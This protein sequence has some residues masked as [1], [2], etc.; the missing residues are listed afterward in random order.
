MSSTYVIGDV[1]GNYNGLV[2]SLQKMGW[3]EN[4]DRLI[5]V[6]DLVD[7]GIANKKVVD[8]VAEHKDTVHVLGNHEQQHKKM[9]QYYRILAKNPTVR[10]LAAGIFLRFTERERIIRASDEINAMYCDEKERKEFLNT[11]PKTFLDY[12]KHF[13]VYTM[14]WEDD[15]LWKLMLCLLDEMCGAPY[16]AQHTIYEY[17]AGSNKTR[18]RFEAV[19]SNTAAEFKIITT[20]ALARY[21]SVR[22]THNNPFGGI[23]SYDGD[24]MLAEHKNTLYVFGHVPHDKIIRIDRERSGCT[25]LD[26]D[27]S[28]DKV[29]IVRLEDI[30]GIISCNLLQS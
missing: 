4:E 6:G 28:P 12:Q 10:K 27:L 18:E 23:H 16:D 17:L 13:I 21:Q 29:G 1:H 20:D 11:V 26:I 5:F 15:S 25:Y 19:F 24:E 30:L 2:E 7:R 22:I 9:V 3:K 14:A 8:F